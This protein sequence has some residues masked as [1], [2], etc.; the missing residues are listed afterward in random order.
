MTFAYHAVPNMLGRFGNRSKSQVSV[1][2]SK[3]TQTHL[4][5][6]LKLSTWTTV[7]TQRSSSSQYHFSLIYCMYY[8]QYIKYA[9]YFYNTVL[10]PVLL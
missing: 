9:Y 3:D 1:A 10:Q 8:V 7:M 4:T 6:N 5:T 2:G